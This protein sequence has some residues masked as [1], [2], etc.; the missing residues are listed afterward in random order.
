MSAADDGQ[1]QGDAL[2]RIEQ[3]V[4]CADRLTC[5]RHDQVALGQTRAGRPAVMPHLAD[6]QAVGVG[7]A[8][9]AAQRLAM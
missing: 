3:V 1:L 4:E 8:D 6:E 7:Q 2:E 5:G 9:G